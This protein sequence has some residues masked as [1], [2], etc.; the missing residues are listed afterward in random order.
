MALLVVRRVGIYRVILMRNEA[1]EL[2]DSFCCII[3]R[4]VP[5]GQSIS[6]AC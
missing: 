4:G 5:L 2:E 1:W 3:Y 6:L